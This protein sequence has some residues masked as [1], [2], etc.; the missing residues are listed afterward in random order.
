MDKSHPSKTPMVVR[1][2]DMN[3]G[4]FKPMDKNEE[5]LGPEVPYLSAIGALMYIANCTRSDIA[6]A[7]NLLARYSVAPMR[8][9]WAGVRNIF[10]YLNG[11]RDLGL[12][13]RHNQDK[14][15]IGYTDA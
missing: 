13:Y 6:F 9:H 3:K 1:S 14:T 15:I 10:R 2:L 5:L 12:L 11:T 4:Q 7:V 8:R